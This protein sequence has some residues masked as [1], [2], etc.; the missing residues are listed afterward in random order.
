MT[1]RVLV[2]GNGMAG[3]RVAEE[4]RRRDPSGHQIAVTVVGEEAHAA[5]NR[6]LLS[7]VVGGAIT[8][9]ETRLKPDG[10]WEAHLIE[11]RTGSRVTAVDTLTRTATVCRVPT[12]GGQPTDASLTDASTQI[13][14]DELVLATG[15]TSFMPRIEG[16][17]VGDRRF[18][19]AQAGDMQLEETDVVAFRSIDDCA[20]LVR[21]ARSAS[22]AIVLGG[23]L[24]GIEAARG[25]LMR[26]V[27][28]TIVHPRSIPMERQLDDDGGAV[29]TRVLRA[30]GAR[31][32]LGRRVTAWRDAAG[33]HG[34]EAV[35]DDGT[36]IAGDL[37]VVAAGILP[38][39]DLAR[40]LGAEVRRGIVVDD[41]LSTTVP[42]VHAVGECVEH[43]GTVYGLV[44]PG[45]EQARVLA[46]V[47]TGADPTSRYEGTE[48]LTRLKVHDI[49]LASMGVVTTGLHDDDHEVVTVA[50]PRRG[51]YAKLV[52]RGDRVVGA[53]L[54][55]AGDVAGAVSQLFDSGAPAPTDRIALLLGRAPGS[56]ATPLD[57]VSLA[58]MPGSAVICRCNSVTKHGIV[59]AWRSGCTTRDAVATATRAT[60]GC[61]SCVAAVDGLCQW[62]TSVEPPD[63]AA[64]AGP[65]SPTVSDQPQQ[66]HPT[67]AFAEGAA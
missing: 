1:T 53:V 56:G 43:R 50:D 38:R 37:L 9:R 36:T 7:T 6:I 2:V 41:R 19:D 58:Q 49:D 34:H 39:V 27:D 28:V 42:H 22:H 60:T 45:W 35:L 3:A 40:D 30:T 61:G 21:A 63:M 64:R 16:T 46:D 59:E 5:Y 11:V 54:L 55:G 20:R 24:L 48:P 47:L 66:H 51:R 13:A 32:I 57:A 31:L 26:G 23:G 12:A 18:D 25:L 4:L 67:A 10:W 65:E 17:Q 44:Q 15:S 62:L 33:G 52:L 8:P 14:W 29:L